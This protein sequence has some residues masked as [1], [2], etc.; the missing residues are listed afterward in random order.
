MHFGALSAGSSEREHY[1]GMSKSGGWRPVKKL[2]LYALQRSSRAIYDP[3]EKIYSVFTY[4]AFRGAFNAE[5]CSM[6][7]HFHDFFAAT[8]SSELAE[9]WVDAELLIL[10]TARESNNFN[11]TIAGRNNINHV[12]HLQRY[13]VF[14]TS[15]ILDELYELI[16][17]GDV[18]SLTLSAGVLHSLLQDRAVILERRKSGASSPERE[19]GPRRRREGFIKRGTRDIPFNV[20]DNFDSFRDASG[21]SAYRIISLSGLKESTPTSLPACCLKVKMSDGTERTLKLP[22]LYAYP[23]EF[24]EVYDTRVSDGE[25]VMAA[26][27]TAAALTGVKVA[28]APGAPCEE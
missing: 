6:R 16:E 21:F 10:T 27:E 12:G 4:N 3:F 8:R 25:D 23:D 19:S 24:F 14:P 17:E 22:S 5:R 28:T 9:S 15:V 7:I 20:Q 13:Q 1:A 11:L 18:T 26:W 2:P